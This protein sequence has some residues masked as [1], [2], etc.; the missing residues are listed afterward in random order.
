MATYKQIQDYIHQTY[1]Y[2]PKTC[3]IANMK[4]VVGLKPKSATIRIHPCPEIK[5]NDLKDAF[6]YFKMI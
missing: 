1:G 4:D 6:K 2:I 5:Q 3:W